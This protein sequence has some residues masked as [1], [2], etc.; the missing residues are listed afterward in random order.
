MKICNTRRHKPV[1][2]VVPRRTGIKRGSE[3]VG[4][5]EDFGSSQIEA[6]SM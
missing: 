4:G 1:S 3:V 6:R 5:Y 2:V